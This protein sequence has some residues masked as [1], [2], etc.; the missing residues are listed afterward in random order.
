MVMKKVETGIWKPEKEGEKMKGVLLNME[1]D[2]G[3]NNSKLYTL[4]VEGKPVGV[5][6][7]TVL[8]PKMVAMKKGNLIE[9]VYLGK[10]KAQAG[11]NAPKLFDVYVDEPESEE[12]VPVEKPGQPEEAEQPGK[13]PSDIPL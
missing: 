8:D 11:K 13:E 7:S 9:I 12:E 10:G 6:G 3:A 5:W 2:I 4:E 1:S